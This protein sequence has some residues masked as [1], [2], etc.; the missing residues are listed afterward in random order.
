VCLRHAV[1]G[2]SIKTYSG[3]G[4]LRVQTTL[5]HPQDFKVYRT[6]ENDPSGAQTSRPLRKGVADLHHRATVCQAANDRY[7]EAL[8]AVKDATPLKEWTDPLCQRM[9]APGKNPQKRKVRALNPLAAAEAA[10]L[11][12]IVDPRFTVNGLRNRDLV[13][14]LY[15]QPATDPQERRRRSGQA[16]RLLRLLRAHGL[17]H[18]VPKTHR[19]QLSGDARKRIT[20]VLAARNANA[21]TLTAIAA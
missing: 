2:N 6:K 3:P 9:P 1:N 8:A 14:L 15:P 18:K 5:N 19:Y 4:F 10:L 13:A 16:T 11:A 20:A 7:A 17:L 21:E 12:G